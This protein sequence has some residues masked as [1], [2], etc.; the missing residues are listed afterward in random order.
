MLSPTTFAAA[1]S[2][3]YLGMAAIP[4][5]IRSENPATIAR[6]SVILWLFEAAATRKGQAT[7]PALQQ[8]LSR[9][10]VA[11]RRPGFTSATSRFAAGTA[12]PKPNPE[13][14]MHRIPMIFGPA[15][16]N[17]TPTLISKSPAFIA[18]RNPHRDTSTP[19]SATAKVEARYWAVKSA[20]AWE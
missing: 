5:A 3:I 20:P 17:P 8:K 11:L 19:E 2:A 13:A 9:F 1:G 7:A 10:N 12:S 18:N 4:I 15:S 16:S 14:A 6:N